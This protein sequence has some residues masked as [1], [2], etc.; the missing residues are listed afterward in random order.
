MNQI[1]LCVVRR[2]GRNQSIYK[3]VFCWYMFVPSHKTS[4]HSGG[5]SSANKKIQL[6]CDCE[7]TNIICLALCKWNDQEQF[8]L[9]SP[10]YSILFYRTRWWCMRRR[11]PKGFS[12]SVRKGEKQIACG[13]KSDT[14][15]Q[16]PP[17]RTTK[18][19]SALNLYLLPRHNLAKSTSRECVILAFLSIRRVP[20]VSESQRAES[21]TVV[22]Q[23]PVQDSLWAM[24]YFQRRSRKTHNA[25]GETFADTYTPSLS[26]NQRAHALL[27][28]ITISSLTFLLMSPLHE[29]W[30]LDRR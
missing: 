8:W 30:F 13:A 10:L 27:K 17:P 5:A 20:K 7:H 2:N 19:A 23:L 16:T 21:I 24:F 18:C 3:L 22:L 11:V 9:G 29:S 12:P 4:A 14:L 28:A 25:S 15:N 26:L 1:S 6:S